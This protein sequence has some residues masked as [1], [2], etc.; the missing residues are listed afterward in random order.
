MTNVTSSIRKMHDNPDMICRSYHPILQYELQKLRGI[1]GFW[2]IVG[3]I[4][5]LG[6]RTGITE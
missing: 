5:F 1:L 6:L 3:G 2:N 4:N